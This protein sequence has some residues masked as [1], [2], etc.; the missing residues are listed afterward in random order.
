MPVQEELFRN[1]RGVGQGLEALREEHEAI[2]NKLLG[3]IDVLTPDERQL[4]DEKAAIVDK[5]LE[6][7]RLG[8]EEA[9]VKNYFKIFSFHKL[10]VMTALASHLQNLEAEKQKYKAQVRR[11]CQENAWIR[12]ELNSTQQQLR[13][14]M[15]VN[16]PVT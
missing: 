1:V 12:D 4:I 2:K 8:I 6:N 9:H 13:Q 11:L 14:S 3:G 7:I 5:N 15:Q 16:I 10:Q